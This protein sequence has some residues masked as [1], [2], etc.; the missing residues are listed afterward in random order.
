LRLGEWPAASSRIEHHAELGPTEFPACCTLCYSQLVRGLSKIGWPPALCHNPVMSDAGSQRSQSHFQFSV[1][2]LLF[3]TAIA[4]AALA[5]YF[6]AARERI[7]RR[8]PIQFVQAIHR[9]DLPEVDRLLKIDPGLAHGVHHGDTTFAQTPLTMALA[10]GQ[11]LDR[12]LQEHPNLDER[13]GHGQTAL[14]VAAAQTLRPAVE[15]LLAVGADPNVPDDDGWICLHAAVQTDRIG[16]ITKLLLDAGANPN[17]AGDPNDPV[18]DNRS[19]LHRAAERGRDLAVVHL[20]N[21]GAQVDPRDSQGQTALHLAVARNQGSVASLLIQHGGDLTAKDHAGLIPGERADG[22]NPEIAAVLWWELIAKL[23]EERKT[24]DLNR[25][26]DAAPR[27]IFFRTGYPPETML[28]HA[29]AARRLDAVEYLLSRMTEPSVRAA[30]AEKSFFDACQSH[31]PVVFAQRL[32]EAGAKIGMENELGQ[33]AVH[34]AAKYHHRDVIRLLLEKGADLSARDN[35]GATVLDA[36]INRHFP[37]PEG[38]KTLEML[39]QAG[40]PPTVLYA[41]ATGDIE[42]LRK[43]TGDD[44][45]ALSREYTGDGVRPLHAAMFGRQSEVVE[46]LLKQEIPHDLGRAEWMADV[47]D[48]LLR[49]ALS[50]DMSDIAVLLIDHG[51]EVNRQSPVGDYPLQTVIE[52]QRDPKIL[53]ALLAHGADPTLTYQ[54]KSASEWAKESK[55]KHRSRYLELLEAAKEKVGGGR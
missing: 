1:R 44:P 47:D 50:G 8:R 40:H 12:I 46:W 10:N 33:T 13:S 32:I 38:H 24:D 39:R 14:Y 9:G 29:V 35:S 31:V 20:L 23:L 41:A 25:I 34:V 7:A 48:S 45:A 36:A 19:P 55:S 37:Y 3:I 16:E 4:A 30:Q 6:K 21:A 18:L 42:L 26:L 28:G 22:T 2:M 49:V 51:A 27:A 54:D 17:N 11:I 52:W 15:R 5:L 53:E 43:L